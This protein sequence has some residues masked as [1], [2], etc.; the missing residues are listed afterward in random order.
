LLKFKADLS[1]EYLERIRSLQEGLLAIIDENYNKTLEQKEMKAQILIQAT[2]LIFFTY[3]DP[4]SGIKFID[5][6]QLDSSR[7]EG[8]MQETV[9]DEDTPLSHSHN[10]N[11]QMV[12]QRNSHQIEPIEHQQYQVQHQ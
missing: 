2:K 6:P 12:G 4:A 5:I 8:A 9:L 11:I 1:E 3:F 10:N 7:S